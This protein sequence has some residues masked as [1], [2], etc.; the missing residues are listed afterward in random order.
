MSLPENYFLSRIAMEETSLQKYDYKGL[1]C[2]LA[3]YV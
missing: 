1:A 3:D 2:K